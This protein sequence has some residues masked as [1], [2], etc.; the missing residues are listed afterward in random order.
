MMKIL[1]VCL[2]NICRS[3]LAEGIL[4]HKAKK[5]GLNWQIDSAGTEHYHIGQPPHPLSQKVAKLNGIDICNQRAR[6]FV[7]EDFDR[8]DKIYAM[9]EDVL[10]EIKRIAKEKYNPAKVDLFLNELYP[11]EHMSVPDPWYGT[12]PDYHHVYKLIDKVCDKIISNYAPEAAMKSK[13]K[14]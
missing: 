9:A 7:K 2:G 13:L 3:P 10:N 8:Y 6:Q 1:M 11:G 12:E 4:Q 5:A 14:L